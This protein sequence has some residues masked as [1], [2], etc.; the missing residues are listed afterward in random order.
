MF[1]YADGIRRVP[2]SI[3]DDVA[4]DIYQ[5]YKHHDSDMPKVI[6]G[7]KTI[8]KSLLVHADYIEKLR[9]SI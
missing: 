3:L 7:E 8:R 9:V 2:V 1:S 5:M 6:M 4:P